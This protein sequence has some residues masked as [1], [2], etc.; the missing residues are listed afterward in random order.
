MNAF[1]C[2]TCVPLTKL[3]HFS[4]TYV[5]LVLANGDDSRTLILLNVEMLME[6][7]QSPV[8]SALSLRILL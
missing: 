5:P 4:I 8:F 7:M 1:Q 6:T 2:G 3:W